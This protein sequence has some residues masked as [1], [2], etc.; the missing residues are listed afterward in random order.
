MV[1]NDDKK[2]IRYLNIGWPASIHDKKVAQPLLEIQ[3]LHFFW[4]I[5]FG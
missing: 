2:H 1:A 5:P 4:G 3:K